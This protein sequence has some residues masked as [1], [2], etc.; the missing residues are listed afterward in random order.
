MA[1]ES[2]IIHG[3]TSSGVGFA[4]E[5]RFLRVLRMEIFALCGE[6]DCTVTLEGNMTVGNSSDT[7]LY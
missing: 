3:V 6:R 1:F 4:L 5:V 2:C 7:F